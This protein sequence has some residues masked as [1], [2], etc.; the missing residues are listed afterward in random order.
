[1]VIIVNTKCTNNQRSSTSQNTRSV[2]KFD[3]FPDNF[4]K[5]NRSYL[6]FPKAVIMA[7]HQR[8]PAE[9]MSGH[10]HMNTKNL[11]TTSTPSEFEP[12][13]TDSSSTT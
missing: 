7:D 2:S 12:Y 1:M 5:C 13:S 4:T 10:N 8:R 9:S 11:S 6:L 3:V